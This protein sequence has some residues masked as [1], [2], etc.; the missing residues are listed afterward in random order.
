MSTPSLYTDNLNKDKKLVL[1]KYIT[2][3]LSENR[4]SEKKFRC[5]EC[6]RIVAT[7]YNDIRAII[8]SNVS[9]DQ[10][11]NTKPLANLCRDC[12]VMYIFV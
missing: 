2:V 11:K 6:G 5:C 12:N 3:V 9:L 1:R 7:S 4:A 8:Q 10:V